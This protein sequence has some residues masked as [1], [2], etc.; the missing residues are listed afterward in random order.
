VQTPGNI[1]KFAKFEVSFAI[2]STTAANPYF[3]YATSTPPG[4]P[5]G[6][7]ITVDM[8]LLPPGMTDWSQAQVLPC[9]Y[10]QPV[11]EVGSGELAESL[12]K[13]QPDWRCRFT[14]QSVGIWQYKVRAVDAGGTTTTAVHQFTCV[15]ST[16]KGFIRVSSTDSRYFEF[17]D[18]TPFVAPLVNF[19]EGNPFNGLARLRQNLQKYGQNGVRFIRWFPTGEGANYDN[20]PFGEDIRSSW[21]FGD[22]WIDYV[23]ADTAAGKRFSF[24]PYYYSQQRFPAVHGARYR[25]S[26]RAKV[27][28]DKVFRPEITKDLTPLGGI[29][30]CA[31]AG[32]CS[33]PVTGWNDYSFQVTNNVNADVLYVYLHDG[34]SE[35]DNASGDILVHS[36]RLQRDETGQGGWGPNLLARSDPDT[37]SYIDQ[38]S[39]ARLDEIFR[40]SEQY[41]V[42][43]KLPLFNKNDPLLNRFLPDGSVTDVWDSENNNFYSQDGWASRWYQRAYTRYFIARWS[44]SPALH[45]LELA[46]ENMLSQPSY[47]AGFALAQYVRSTSPR[48]ILMSNS[49][50]GWF[51]SEFWTD[52][53]RGY[54]VDYADKHWYANRTGEGDGELISATTNDSAVN[55]RECWRRFNE[56]KQSFD[57]NQPIVRGETGVAVSGTQPQDP[58]IAR[59]TQGTYYHKQ[60]W[61]Q[62]GSVGYQCGGEWY[63]Q[64]MDDYNLWGQYAAFE[65]FMQ[66]VSISNGRYTAI[67]TDLSGAAQISLADVTGSL[68]AWGARDASA[69]KVLLWID[70]SKHTWRNVVDQVTVPPASGTLTVQGL[71]KGTYTAQWWNTLDG[72]VALTQTYT[73][74]D[75]GRLVLSVSQLATDKAIKLQLSTPSALPL[76]WKVYLPLI[77]R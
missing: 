73:V 23:N 32:R 54:L 1:E 9:F 34:L 47:D 3:P 35:N 45:S 43:H 52:P 48:H 33:D 76:P 6:I 64:L 21:G 7:G 53:T 59:D 60:L 70:N 65:R 69:G 37:Y 25:L 67:G 62:V 11:E 31:Q 16:R 4:V 55:V 18:G 17:S 75:N 38:R 68:R 30:I 66:G 29:T 20:I 41:G 58:D 5:G 12:P 27:V 24:T 72:T 10:Y 13:G 15:N 39:A 77:T 50:W 28:G 61:A 2:T 56:Y 8:L 26:L 46:N 51:V 44:Y 74:S 36:I 71:P 19:E 57:Y 49:F 40:L 14:P 63:P 22:G 42:Y